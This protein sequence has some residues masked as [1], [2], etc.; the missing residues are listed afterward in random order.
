MNT[1]RLIQVQKI[2][3]EWRVASDSQ[4]IVE[5]LKSPEVINYEVRGLHPDTRYRMQVQAHNALGYSL[6]AQL[7]VQTALGEYNQE[8]NEVPIR[9]GFY[10][11]YTASEPMHSKATT[12]SYFLSLFIFVLCF[13]L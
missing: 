3:G 2:T 7:Y 10:D 8:S 12:I 9:A 5:E 1:R 13:V 6:P 11:V 4:C